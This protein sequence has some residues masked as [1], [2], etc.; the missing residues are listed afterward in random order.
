MVVLS[1]CLQHNWHV[2]KHRQCYI[3]IP[4]IKVSKKLA[5]IDS[6]LSWNPHWSEW[7]Y[8]TMFS[9]ILLSLYQTHSLHK[10]KFVN[11]VT[12]V[13]HCKPSEKGADESN[14]GIKYQ[15][16]QLHLTFYLNNENFLSPV[17]LPWLAQFSATCPVVHP[18]CP[19]YGEKMMGGVDGC[20]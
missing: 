3:C 10:N 12:H 9:F 15:L 11:S 1:Q 20:W 8:L 13:L 17:P 6:R 2:H 16:I 14:K 5:N 19:K 18:R 7:P 4:S